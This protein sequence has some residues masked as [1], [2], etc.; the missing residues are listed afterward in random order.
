MSCGGGSH[1][2]QHLLYVIIIIIIILERK[3]GAG[4]E[5]ERIS[6]QLHTELG[7]RLR[8]LSLN[9]EIMT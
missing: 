8:A 3:K 2:Q 6:N 7:A 9:P 5:G 4:A 1:L